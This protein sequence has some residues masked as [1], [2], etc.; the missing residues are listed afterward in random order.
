MRRQ[1]LEKDTGDAEPHGLEHFVVLDGR[2]EQDHAG[3]VGLLLEGAQHPEAVESR[4]REV[5]KQD[6]RAMLPHGL[7]GRV[8]TT[9][10]IAMSDKRDPDVQ[11]GAGVARRDRPYE[12]G[13]WKIPRH[14]SAGLWQPQKGRERLRN[15]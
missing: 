1:L 13:T 8:A 3:G 5:E 10:R 7:E 12:R 15:A 2:R 11:T 6:V 9:S 14:R 4:H